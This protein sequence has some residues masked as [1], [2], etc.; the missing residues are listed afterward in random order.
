MNKSFFC[1]ALSLAVASLHGMQMTDVQMSDAQ[2][3]AKKSLEIINVALDNNSERDEFRALAT[4][5]ISKSG[6]GYM[7]EFWKLD[8]PNIHAFVTVE[9]AKKFAMASCK[10]ANNQACSAQEN[11]KIDEQIKKHL[12]MHQ[13]LY[14]NALQNAALVKEL[15]KIHKL[16]VEQ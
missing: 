14:V 16:D 12:K 9:I 8:N 7:K 10:F 11:P 5:E 4:A 3:N 13:N 15:E 1:A 6:P 2:K